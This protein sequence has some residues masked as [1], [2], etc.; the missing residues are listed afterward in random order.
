MKSKKVFLFLPISEL[1]L[2]LVYM[3]KDACR[4]DSNSNNKNREAVLLFGGG[5]KLS[6]VTCL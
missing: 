6:G 2:V 3:A 1:C 5:A 4:Q